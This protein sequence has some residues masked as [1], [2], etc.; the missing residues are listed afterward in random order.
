MSYRGINGLQAID[1][2]YCGENLGYQDVNAPIQ[3]EHWQHNC[4][5]QIAD[6]WEVPVE[7]VDGLHEVIKHAIAGAYPDITGTLGDPKDVPQIMLRAR[8]A[9]NRVLAQMA[10]KGYRLKP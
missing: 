1:C 3:W 6:E 8:L 7:F 10:Q 4:T 2:K 5:A 9:A